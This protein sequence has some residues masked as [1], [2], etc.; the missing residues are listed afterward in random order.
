DDAQGL[1]VRPASTYDD[2]TPNPNSISAQNLV[3]LAMLSG[4][5]SWRARADRLF[6]GVLA[7]ASDN[8]FAHTALLNALDLRLRGAEIVVTGEGGETEALLTAARKLP[9][10]DRVVLHARTAESLP[11]NHPAREKIAGARS[12]AAFVCVGERCSLPVRSATAM[13]E[14]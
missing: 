12:G 14:T 13:F 4:D 8:L 7:G 9:F 11:A 5:D 6:D 2:A 3:R 1:I 10:I